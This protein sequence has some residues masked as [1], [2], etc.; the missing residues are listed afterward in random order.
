VK[1]RQIEVCTDGRLRKTTTIMAIGTSARTLVTPFT[2][3]Q[4]ASLEIASST[5]AMVG[6]IIRAA[7]YIPELNATA[8]GRSDLAGTISG[9]KDWRIGASIAI[10]TPSADAITM[11]CQTSTTSRWASAASVNA[12]S[13]AAD[14]VTRSSF[15][16]S[17]RSAHSP[18]KGASTSTAI[19][20]ANAV[21]PSS[22]AEPVRR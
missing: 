9:R 1:L 16:R 12:G 4:N 14:W 10:T 18:P 2:R 3:K 5:P 20:P 21:T 8:L 15:L 19:C 22:H 13:A 7:L 6:P 11:T 17:T